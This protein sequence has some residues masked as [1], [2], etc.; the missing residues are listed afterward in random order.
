M[1]FF[2]LRDNA[3]S[4]VQWALK[5]T[6]RFVTVRDSNGERFDVSELILSLDNDKFR[7]SSGK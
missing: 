3:Q 1:L 4:Y 5:F 2:S 6:A 7:L